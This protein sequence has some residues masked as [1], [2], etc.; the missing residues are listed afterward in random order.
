MAIMHLW[1]TLLV[2][3]AVF[4]L[5][6]INSKWDNNNMPFRFVKH[7]LASNAETNHLTSHMPRKEPSSKRMRENKKAFEVTL[8]LGSAWFNCLSRNKVKM[9]LMYEQPYFNAACPTRHCNS[10]GEKKI[11][12]EKRGIQCELCTWWY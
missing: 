8:L 6:T 9:G 10:S 2:L 5:P 4:F 12:T 11:T 7:C 3:S 1:G